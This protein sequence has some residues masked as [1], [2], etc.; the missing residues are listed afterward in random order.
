MSVIHGEG[1]PIR[2][3]V[4]LGEGRPQITISAPIIAVSIRNQ[5]PS[6]VDSIS[7]CPVVGT[8]GHSVGQCLPDL[9]MLT[10]TGSGFLQWQRTSLQMCIGIVQTPLVLMQTSTPGPYSFILNDTTITINLDQSHR[11]LLA[12]H[13]FD[14]RIFLHTEDAIRLAEQADVD[15]V[16]CAAS[17]V[18]HC[19][20][21]IR[22][23]QIL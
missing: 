8:D 12:A 7:G 17:A 21:A 19:A 11:Y 9:N 22:D 13:D 20:A 23:V 2:L 4:V 5:P 16:R 15:T 10:L 14:A 18:V 3:T 6:I 1:V